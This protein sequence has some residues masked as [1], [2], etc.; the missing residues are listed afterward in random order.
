[1]DYQ[2]STSTF[3]E[4]STNFLT[5]TIFSSA[6]ALIKL[7]NSG[8]A[9]E[10]D[11][12]NG[13][14]LLFSALLSAK[15]ISVNDDLALRFATRAP[16][17]WKFLGAGAP[18]SP[19]KPD[20]LFL[21]IQVRMSASHVYDCIWR[22]RESVRAKE[23]PTQNAATAVIGSPTEGLDPFSRPVDYSLPMD[24]SFAEMEDLDLFNSMDWMLGD[25]TDLVIDPT[26]LG[27]QGPI[28]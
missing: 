28:T 23:A 27:T 10:F 3:L 12:T 9:N 4:Y 5:Q 19:D 24:H 21:K 13:K 18:W 14:A 7:L 26:G 17:V 25:W 1:M 2:L 11:V 6:F 20:P 16:Q 22:W 8:F 15:S